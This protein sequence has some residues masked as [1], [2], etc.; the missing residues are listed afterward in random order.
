MISRLKMRFAFLLLVGSA[1]LFLAFPDVCAQ[2]FSAG[3]E[4]CAGSLLPA[5]FP[6]FVVSNLILEYAEV[7]FIAFPFKSLCKVYKLNSNKAV[8]LLLLG[9]LGGY[10]VLASGL[11]ACRARGEISARE[12]SLLLPIGAVCSPGFSAAVGSFMLGQPKLGLVLYASCLLAGI[13][14]GIIARFAAW[15]QLSDE[16]ECSVKQN[17][18]SDCKKGFSNAINSAVQS[19]LQVCGSVIFFR[20]ILGFGPIL[21]LPLS[22]Q[23]TLAG[24]LEVSS[25]CR[26]WALLSGNM[27]LIGCCG[28]MSILSL[29]VWC[30]I[31]A[32]SQ[33]KYSLLPLALTRPFHLALSLL[34]MK[35]LL[36]FVPGDLPALHT[37]SE[38][39]IFRN[40]LPGDRALLLFIFCCLVLNFLEKAS[41]YRKVK[42][43]YNNK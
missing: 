41:L 38:T 1:V 13:V 23:A 30:Q 24:L 39:V 16:S 6:F 19:S 8:L 42:A 5:L 43:N 15:P 12:A 18:F 22:M 40:R 3:V 33:G 17:N 32:L 9:W 4:L 34:F 2:G 21:N 37:M 29:S 14:C 11:A 31:K 25:G 28:C 10:T 7:D 27:A 35:G 26:A 20:M 36:Y